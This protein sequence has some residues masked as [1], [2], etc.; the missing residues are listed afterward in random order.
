MAIANFE[1]LCAGFCEVIGV[2]PPALKADAN[3]LVAF[4][5]IFRD[6]IVNLVHRP[7]VSPDHVFVVFEVGPLG[8]DRERAS[9]QFQAFLEA[10]FVLLQ[11]N[12]PVFSRNPATGDAI[13]QYVYSLFEASPSGLYE[14]INKGIDTIVQCREDLPAVAVDRGHEHESPP[15]DMLLHIA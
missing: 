5:V 1:E 7:D 2:A 14:L 11:V 12:P 15:L 6:M 10:N 4:H 13:L 3:G 8:E 9:V